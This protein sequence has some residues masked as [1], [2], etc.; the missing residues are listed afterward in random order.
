VKPT[1]HN[2]KSASTPK[3][4]LFALLCGLPRVKGSG[5]SLRTPL[6][7]V[8]FATIA[9]LL[10]APAFSSV[11]RAAIAHDFLP[12]PSE[13]ISKGVPAGAKAAGGEAALTGPVGG[14][15]YYSMSVAPGETP[16]EPGHLWIT[17]RG[18]VDEF[19]ASSGKWES[20]LEHIGSE[21]G[22]NEEYGVAVG[23][24]TGEREVYV[25]AG[26]AVAVFGPTG[27]L[28]ATWTG[29]D[30]PGGSFKGYTPGLAVDSSTSALDEREGD[31]YVGTSGGIG[32]SGGVVDVFEP[33][34]GGKEKYVT[35][36]TGTCPVEGTV[37]GAAGCEEAKIVPF[38][39][40]NNVVPRA[41]VDPAN[42][43]VLVAEGSAVD[44]FKPMVLDQYEFVRQI[45]G[46]PGHSFA[47]HP[48][49]GVTAGGGEGDGDFYVA[50]GQY[51][52]AGV[53]VYE[54]NSEGVYLGSLTKTPAGP[55]RDTVSVAVD[56][57]SGDVYVGDN[58]GDASGGEVDAFGPDL[59]IPD[60]LT[61]APS[62][63]TPY[64]AVLNGTVNPLKEGKASCQ[65]AWGT[66][67]ALGHTVECEPKE[68]AEGNAPVKVHSEELNGLLRPDTKYF[69]RLEATNRNG[70]NTGAGSEAECEGQKAPV[71]CFTT[72]GPGIES[73]SASEVTSTSVTLDAAVNPNNA[74]TSYLFEYGSTTNYG[75]I[76]PGA[77]I[78]SG[79]NAVAVDQLVQG[80]SAGTVYH[81][82]VVAESE[83]EPGKI[84]VFDGSDQTFTT[85]T[86]G[87]FGLL[88]GREWEMV[89]SPQKLGALLEPINGSPDQ[90]GVVQAA[91]DGSAI[92]YVADVPTESRPGGYSDDVEVL[93]S[94]EA[95][96]GA[97]SSGGWETHDLGVPAAESTR[98][99]VGGGNEYRFFSEDLSLAVVQP[100]GKFEPA[101]SA[102]GSEQT[103]YLH[104]DTTG[105]YTPLVS[106]CPPA[107][108]ACPK[109]V[110]E[111]ADVAPG[112]I[113]A[114]Y[115]KLEGGEEGSR[116]PP[117]LICGPV[118]EG[119]SPDASHIVLHS[120]VALTAQAAGSK[121]DLYEWS[122]ARPSAEKLQLVSLLP[123]N[124]EGREL[125]T[126][127]S[128]GDGEDARGAISD[129]GSR[130]FW[131]AST[132][133]QG[134]HLYMR[135]MTS[136]K[137]LQIDL[138]EPECVAKHECIEGRGG[139]G[140]NF[141]IASSDGSRV[142]FTDGQ[143]LTSDSSG[144][145]DLFEC[146]IS[147]VVGKPK[148]E[149]SDLT[150]QSGS[151][152]PADVQGVVLGASE[153]G[154]W[155]YFVANGVFAPGATPG[156]CN[157]PFTPQ[158]VCNLYVRHDGETKLV[159]VV[160]GDD[161]HD[162]SGGG[163][164]D[165][166]AMT[167]RVSPDGEWLAFMSDRDLTGDDPED[168]TSRQPGERLDEEVYLYSA[169]SRRLVCAACNPSGARPV[170]ALDTGGS[171]VD[172][173]GI[174]GG[175]IVAD[176][177]W[178]AADIPEWTEYRLGKAVYQ[179]RY[180]SNSGRLF[181][182]SHDALV[183]LDV[184]GTW[185]VYE[186]EP[187]GV[188]SCTSSTD[189]GG[190]VFKPA[191]TVE[192]EGRRVEE[193][194]GCVGLISSGESP[195]E[196]AFLDASATGGRNSEGAEGGGDVFFLTT[197]RLSRADFDDNYDVYDAHE[198]TAASPCVQAPVVP[199]PCINEASCK[200]APTPQPT[201]FGAPSSATFSGAGNLIPEPPRPSPKKVTKK[202]VKCKKSKKRSRGKCVQEKSTKKARKSTRT[203][204]RDRSAR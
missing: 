47:P 84:T 65:F 76:A 19:N 99:A 150:P 66:S 20:Q 53:V 7:L 12:A 34:A 133:N 105:A 45:T 199:P 74:P 83:I 10:G 109:T 143:Q 161:Y 67:E 131:A 40:S 18:R 27:K 39:S 178:L 59:V 176:R 61:G 92:G 159:A 93:S 120:Q 148:C 204:S 97:S 179:S 21:Y 175:A 136:E 202:V 101:L 114:E 3:T 158:A 56:P 87:A 190:R 185:D 9:S 163:G 115:G 80:L 15:S 135:D 140:A 85:Q 203:S 128:L 193:G 160:S 162:W 129:D 48:I 164:G 90:G 181:F 169:R 107:G 130:V 22:N 70:T 63:V 168:V 1:E 155:V 141:Q 95:G 119:A 194:A 106:G 186:Y 25:T 23:R 24:S 72:S 174:W 189:S 69:D 124:A 147:E 46:I 50:E 57:A 122:T 152:G 108:A 104:N 139:G 177:R 154:S 111:H 167:A 145:V 144:G 68:V 118:F 11:A 156:D 75:S 182:N 13:A 116:C 43:D 142:F 89:S 180:L 126:Y 78:G 127:G 26:K 2:A 49:D 17:G 200:A 149:L 112:T 32:T 192:V 8:T 51:Y 123:P 191:R 100:F 132:V 94:R 14:E 82:R 173:N 113:F 88:D 38:P 55:F 102:E 138:P 4:G 29:A 31:V 5:A 117:A 165:L 64:S 79:T 44:I 86:P 198:C 187:E 196:S 36:L 73:E 6:V 197:S 170:G 28:Q 134:E 52:S 37:V 98:A 151:G 183:P 77:A 81:Y 125:P 201:I 137:T 71:A 172:A 121:G 96:G 188:G 30:T 166:S 16:G 184:N 35:Q 91:A 171:I 195:D 60:V 110:E 103:A 58:R 157:G 153:D 41:A 146:V 62:E 54:F 33:E 42:G